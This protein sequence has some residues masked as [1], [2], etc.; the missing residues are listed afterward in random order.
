MKR[1]GFAMAAV[2]TVIAA[3]VAALALARLVDGGDVNPAREQPSGQKVAFEAAVLSSQKAAIEAAVL[4]YETATPR[5]RL[6]ATR[7]LHVRKVECSD[8]GVP[9]FRGHRAFRCAI[10]FKEPR[11]GLDA[12]CF[13]LVR[14]ALYQVG[15]CFDPL[16]DMGAGKSR[17]LTS[18]SSR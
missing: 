3:A 12:A 11:T 10:S 17:L 13:V 1:R 16:R 9:R 7:L 5:R 4:R 18:S 6:S 8:V 14:R 15:G 2:A